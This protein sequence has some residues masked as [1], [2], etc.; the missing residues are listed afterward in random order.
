MAFAQNG[1]GNI[2]FLI[3]ND[4]WYN[5]KNIPVISLSNLTTQRVDENYVIQSP[6]GDA[7]DNKQIH[8]EDIEIEMLDIYI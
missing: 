1:H 4:L 2:F 6:A 3:R 5:E 8:L 7:I